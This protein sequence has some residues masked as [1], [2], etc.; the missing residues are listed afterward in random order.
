M[1][2]NVYE[3]CSDSDDDREEIARLKADLARI[4]DELGLPPGIGPAPGVIQNAWKGWKDALAEVERLKKENSDCEALRDEM[5]GSIE[6]MA[7]TISA[8][9]RE[10]GGM[11]VKIATIDRMLDTAIYQS[12][13][14]FDCGAK[15]GQPHDMAC[16]F[17]C[18]ENALAL[19]GGGE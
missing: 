10:N 9:E 18:H 11:R 17:A 13:E 16:G 8:L 6:G 3:R 15:R 12:G 1:S 19:K 7:E 5:R 14:C 4:S 2:E